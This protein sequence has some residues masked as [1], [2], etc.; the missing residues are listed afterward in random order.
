MFLLV[1]KANNMLS[2]Q[3]IVVARIG[4]VPNNTSL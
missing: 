3:I 1:A 4:C 2:V